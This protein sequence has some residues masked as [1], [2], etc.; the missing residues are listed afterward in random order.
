LARK[1][2]EEEENNTPPPLQL[3]SEFQ[4]ICQDKKHSIGSGS[5]RSYLLFLFHTRFD[6]ISTMAKI[7]SK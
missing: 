2:E 7:K 5:N 3:I 4:I 1:G 6:G